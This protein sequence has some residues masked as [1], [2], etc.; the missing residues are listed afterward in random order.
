M[1]W[2]IDLTDE[3]FK[4]LVNADV[5]DY[6]GEANPFAHSDL[7]QKLIDL[8]RVLPGAGVYSP[9]FK[10]CAY[11]VLHD[12]GSRIFGL[13]A[14]MR[15][16]SFR[17]PPALQGDLLGQGHGRRSRIGGE[18]FDFAVFPPGGLTPAG[19]ARLAH[20][21]ATAQDYAATLSAKA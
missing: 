18:W 15:D 8:G 7:G 16:L 20:Y 19:E 10:I 12:A 6:I 2:L 3:R 17:L 14:G 21:C 1:T 9:N 13:A 4:I 11:V 5:I